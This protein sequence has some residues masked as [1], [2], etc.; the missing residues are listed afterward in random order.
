MHH[1]L[2]K[3]PLFAIIVALLAITFDTLQR[4]YFPNTNVS[5]ALL[6]STVF[7][8]IMLVILS[9]CIYRIDSV[10]IKEERKLKQTHHKKDK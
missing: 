6:Q 8:L 9:I 1:K 3:L 7:L 5:V 2:H 10:N 4:F